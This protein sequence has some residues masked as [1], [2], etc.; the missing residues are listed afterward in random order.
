MRQALRHDAITEAC[1]YAALDHH[2]EHEAVSITGLIEQSYLELYGN[3]FDIQLE[4]CGYYALVF[5]EAYKNI[6]ILMQEKREWQDLAQSI[7]KEPA[8]RARMLLAR[9]TVMR[10]AQAGTLED[11]IM[12]RKNP[13]SPQEVSYMAVATTLLNIAGRYPHDIERSEKAIAKRTETMMTY[14]AESN[15]HL[16]SDVL[17][18][19]GAMDNFKRIYQRM[20]RLTIARLD[21]RDRVSSQMLGLINQMSWKTMQ[22]QENMLSALSQVLPKGEEL[23]IFMGI[24]DEREEAMV[25]EEERSAYAGRLRYKFHLP[26][27]AVL[28]RKEAVVAALFYVLRC[29]N[30]VI[31]TKE[32]DDDAQ[33]NLVQ[34]AIYAYTAS[35]AAHTYDNGGAYF[36]NKELEAERLYCQQYVITYSSIAATMRLEKNKNRAEIERIDALSNE[37]LLRYC[38]KEAETH[39]ELWT[40]PLEDIWTQEESLVSL[41]DGSE[42]EARCSQSGCTQ[43]PFPVCRI[44]ISPPDTRQVQ[45]FINACRGHFKE[46]RIN[47]TRER[48]TALAERAIHEHSLPENAPVHIMYYPYPDQIV[49][50][51]PGKNALLIE[52]YRLSSR[53]E[54]TDALTQQLVKDYGQRAYHFLC[55]FSDGTID[56]SYKFRLAP[57]AIAVATYLPTMPLDVACKQAVSYRPYVWMEFEQ[58]IAA[59]DGLICAFCYGAPRDDVARY[60]QEHYPL[61]HTIYTQISDMLLGRFIKHSQIMGLDVVREDGTLVWSANMIRDTNNNKEEITIPAWARTCGDATCEYEH[62]CSACQERLEYYFSLYANMLKLCRGELAEDVDDQDR[63]RKHREVTVRATRKDPNPKKLH[64]FDTYSVPHTLRLVQMNALVKRPR[65]V[66]EQ[67]SA[68]RDTYTPRADPKA[69]VYWDIEVGGYKRRLRDPRY[70]DY[71]IS[72]GGDPYDPEFKG[73]EID[74]AGSKRHIR[75]TLSQARNYMTRVSAGR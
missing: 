57:S 33:G 12:R 8:K 22:S 63:A 30:E 45:V 18:D 49:N 26:K 28:L 52:R 56:L 67:E 13:T 11:T 23:S 66:R 15:A 5:A 65:N 73:Y 44:T 42:N 55:A 36:T 6:L 51:K 71:I 54:Y 62:Y 64:K 7:Y 70:F 29:H 37:M 20:Y 14:F 19:R 34:R 50:R 2:H 46:V 68:K 61:S 41:E 39:T 21:K 17:T 27:D 32:S 59:P 75:V 47:S 43:D 3:M 10:A 31:A 72:R 74:V 9:E 4:Q 48:A 16:F 38:H 35:R 40:A 69:M 24:L 60:A 1:V 25:H 53:P 58:P